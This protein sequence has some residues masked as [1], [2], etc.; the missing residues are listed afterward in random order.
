MRTS[1][2]TFLSCILLLPSA[3]PRGGFR[4]AAIIC[5][6]SF[7]FALPLAGQTAAGR[8]PNRVDAERAKQ[9]DLLFSKWD[10]TVSPGCALSVIE[11]GRIIY[12]RGYGMA[13]LDHGVPITPESV[14]HVASMSKQ[15][16]AAAIILLALDGKLSLDD[17]VH[18]YLP[19][20]PDFGA[21]ITILDLMHHTSGIRDQWEL[22]DLA[23]WRYS[24]DLITNQDVL[25]LLYRQ[26]ELN[27]KPGSRF[28]Y[29]NSGYTLLRQIVQQVSHQSLRE[30]TTA[31]IFAPLGMTSTHFRDDHA[32][33]VK[34]DAYGYK[35]TDQPNVYRLSI[36]NFD[37][38]GATGLLTTVEDLAKWDENFYDPRVGGPEFLKLMLR[39][40]V[41]NNGKPVMS[42]DSIYASGLAIGEYRGLKTV[43]HTGSDA[44]Y[45]ADL[46]RFPGQ[47]FSVACLCNRADAVPSDKV[48]QVADIY[49]AKE[50]P[51]PP[52]KKPDPATAFP[53]SARQLRQYAGLY[54]DSENRRPLRLAIHDNVL[55]VVSPDGKN[56]DLVASSAARF[57]DLRGTE[58]YLFQPGKNGGEWQLTV[59]SDGG[60]G[61]K[62]E[63]RKVQAFAPD[64]DAL[65]A[66]AGIYASQEIDPKFTI[67][68]RT[69]GL[70]LMRLKHD[71]EEFRPTI[72]DSFEDADGVNIHFQRDKS[73]RVVGFLWDSG[74]ILN[75]RFTKV[76]S[77]DHPCP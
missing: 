47:H 11:N 48:R 68:A 4:C 13:D 59:Q 65:Q 16:T 39:G 75:F 53:V 73:G 19:Q 1:S 44:G 33:V 51:E 69:G 76:V 6:L 35:P 42:G 30:F 60:R 58:T 61:E 52:R 34:H 56:W 31:R 23:G 24:L 18:K 12:E 54:W 17:D 36:T 49:L 3:S 7:L 70:T 66:Y 57:E 55:A 40:G 27:F 29:D 37:T 74:R 9:T 26:K 77:P 14:F 15:F 28:L 8:K 32:E 62:I 72:A 43:E 50:F 22:L 21:K 2:L 64:E 10:T 41:L 67:I 45:R 25:G 38:V 63:Y 20:L 46:I 5:A 71:P